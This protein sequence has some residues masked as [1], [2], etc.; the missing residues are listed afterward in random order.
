MSFLRVFK[1]VLKQLGYDPA[2]FGG[3]SFLH[4][5]ATWASKA[6]LSEG[7]IKML[8]LW[9]SDC[10]QHYI[11]ADYVKVLEALNNFTSIL[12]H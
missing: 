12:P 5:A 8:G 7:E 11:V 3:H 1:L 2:L 6:G 9:A 10:F 4:G